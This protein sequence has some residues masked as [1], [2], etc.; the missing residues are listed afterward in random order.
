MQ[1]NA[2]NH[3]QMQSIAIQPN[4]IKKWNIMQSNALNLQ[5][6]AIKCIQM[7]WNPTKSNKMH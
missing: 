7:Q 3:N 6:N 4:Q 1:S 5:S 2:T